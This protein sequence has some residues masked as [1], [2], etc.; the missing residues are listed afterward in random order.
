[1]EIN[2]TCRLIFGYLLA[3]VVHIM[4]DIVTL[5]TWKVFIIPVF[6]VKNSFI[7]QLQ[8]IMMQQSS[9]KWKWIKNTEQTKK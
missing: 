8:T 1:M 4:T 3:A 2:E 5:S 6:E 9:L 7:G